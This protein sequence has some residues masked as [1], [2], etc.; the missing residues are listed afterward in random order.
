VTAAGVLGRLPAGAR[1]LVIRLR[2]LGDCVL[3]TPALALLK[4]HR[5]D[6][7]VAVV[8]EDRFAAVFEGNRDVDEVLA[9][10]LAPVG[11][12]R[13]ML[14][15]NLH[16]GS[17]SLA[18][19]LASG[20]PHRAGFAHFRFRAAYNIRIPRAQ[21]ILGV[22]RV[23]HTVEHLASAMFY[24]GVPPRPI[25]PAKLAA[26]PRAAERPYAVIHPFAAAPEKTWPA[27]RFVAVADHLSRRWGFEPIFIGGRE[28]DFTPFR[29]F[30]TVAGADLVEV[31]NLIAGA[32]LF[33]G[34][35]SGPAHIAAAFGVPVAVIFGASDPRIWGPWRCRSEVLV[36]R[37]GIA[38]V[39]PEEMIEALERLRGRP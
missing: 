35:D 16:G 17:R 19:T 11:R 3:T 28:D 29:R 36:A 6:L 10:A 39:R 27:D 18:L 20:A 15:L 37:E 38:R 23:V 2:S 1:M 12:W 33:A 22:E 13:A 4:A 32:A 14:C 26:Q 21:E 30:R 9:P 7:R 24:L 5:P 31:K 8:A 34:N 25:P